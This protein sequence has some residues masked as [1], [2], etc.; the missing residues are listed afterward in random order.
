MSFCRNTW[1]KST[2]KLHF[3]WWCG[4]RIFIGCHACYTAGLNFEG[5]FFD[6]HTHPECQAAVD[7]SDDYG[8]G[9]EEYAHARGR[10]DDDRKLPAEFSTDYRGKVSA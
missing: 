7:V 8:E 6:G 9:F 10:T 3:C 4:E 1:I 2:R 5:E